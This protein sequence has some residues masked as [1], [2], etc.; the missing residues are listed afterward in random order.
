M[1]ME[2][3]GRSD[4]RGN[5]YEN[6]YLVNLLL[7]LVDEKLSSIIIE[8]VGENSAEFIAETTDGKKIYYQ[9][10]ASNGQADHWRVSDLK[11]HDVWKRAKEIILSDEENYY[12]FVSPV[13]YGD[14][15]E[16]CYRARTNNAPS[17]FFKKQIQDKYH[18]DLVRK[19]ASEFEL[20]IEKEKDKNTLVYILSH[21]FF[22]LAPYTRDTVLNL[23]SQ[24]GVHFAG[25]QKAARIL[26]EQFANSSE[27]YGVKFIPVDVVNY[28]KKKQFEL[29]S[30]RFDDR[31]LPQ[32]EKLNEI[33]WGTFPAINGTLIHR[34][35]TEQVLEKLDLGYSIVLHGRAGSGKSGC[36][37][38]VIEEL[39][40]RGTPYLSIKLD[41]CDP[42]SSANQFG[43]SLDLQESPV[44]ALNGISGGKPCV[45][46]F[47]QLDALRWTA[48]HSSNALSVCK[49]I[50][51]QMRAINRRKEGKISI[52]F[53]SRT[54]D[55][56]NDAGIKELFRE[57]EEHKDDL[58]E[59]VKVDILSPSE[60]ENVVGKRFDNMSSRLK[61][62][63]QT[64]SSLYVWTQLSDE[65]KSRDIS[66][67]FQLMQRWWEQ[68]LAKSEESGVRSEIADKTKNKLVSYIESNNITA[69]PRVLL[70]YYADVL[71]VFLSCGLILKVGNGVAFA[72]QS[73]FD[74]FITQA[75]LDK[76]FSGD[77]I[78][79]C[80]SPYEQQTPQR[81][82]R[83]LYVLQVLLETDSSLFIKQSENLLCSE[84]VHYYYKCAVFE[85]AGQCDDPNDQLFAFI[86]KYYFLPE[87]SET[88]YQSVILRHPG[89]VKK[90]LHEIDL[91]DE[92]QLVLLQSISDKD[93]DFV[94]ECLKGMKID[95]LEDAR[96]VFSVFP[97]DPSKDS[98]SMFRYR[99]EL[100][101][102]FPE[103]FNNFLLF[104]RLIKKQP[105]KAIDFLI[106]LLN[107]ESSGKIDKLYIGEKKDI[108]S[109]SKE[110]YQE[111]IEKLLPVI[112][113]QTSDLVLSWPFSI[114]SDKCKRFEDW[115]QEGR[116]LFSTEHP[117]RTV[118]NIT[119]AAVEEYARQSP[120]EMISLAN[121]KNDSA[122]CHEIIMYGL[123]NLNE[124]L[125]DYVINWI[126]RDFNARI[127]VF[128]GDENDY[129]LYTKQAIS[130]FSPHCT[131]SVFRALENE[132]FRWNEGTSKMVERLRIRQEVNSSKENEPVYYAYWGHLQKELLA[133]MDS[134]RLSQYGE[135]LLAVLNRN[136]W[137]RAPYF[138]CGTR[139]G[140]AKTVVSP[141]D[142]YVD[143]LSDKV[144]MQ[145]IGTPAEKMKRHFGG[146][147][148]EKH[149]I[150]ASHE[151]FSSSMRSQAKKQP[152]RFAELSFAFPDNCY[153]GYICAVLDAISQQSEADN[154]IKDDTLLNRL[155]GRF[156]KDGNRNVLIAV[157]RVV[158]NCKTNW[159][160][161]VIDDIC[162]IALHYAPESKA[163]F[164]VTDSSDP[165]H[166]LARSLLENAINTTRGCAVK[167]LSSQL[168]EK[169]AL[170]EK[171]K[172]VITALCSDKN[173]IVRFA[174]F[175]CLLPFYNIDPSFSIEQM[176]ILLRQDGRVCCA[177]GF[178]ELMIRDY[179]NNPQFYQEQLIKAS[180]SGVED[181]SETAARMLASL[182]IQGQKETELS[183]LEKIDYSEE[184][185]NSIARQAV[186]FYDNEEYHEKS[187]EVLKLLIS[188]TNCELRALL[189]L[190]YHKKIIA[191]RDE[192]FLKYVIS[193]EQNRYILPEMLDY[194]NE[195]DGDLTAF[196]EVFADIAIN[197]DD[198]YA[199]WRQQ[200][201][202]ENLIGC[203]LKLLDQGG[204]D[205]HVREVCLTLWDALYKSNL[206]S[207][208]AL[209]K[210]I[211]ELSIE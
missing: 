144:W 160:P 195:Y 135:Q 118:V 120:E 128:T 201:V 49:E 95:S 121:E 78:V 75:F 80:I 19:I 86:C 69:V 111:V 142:Q 102:R 47:D 58:W 87:W 38:E 165:S 29:R 189:S 14:I 40:R 152:K 81:R 192:E 104:P 2:S 197:L 199:V 110:F 157:S 4:K 41:K 21:C 140:M 179:K 117:V 50:I 146:K 138:C 126:L 105:E 32:V 65:D 150:E 107:A 190:F 31:I 55:L 119:I 169:P 112:K 164:T 141:V 9:C 23:E 116:T 98:N 17:E 178:W 20:D 193:S 8:P 166:L 59:Q 37:Q 172:P 177:P 90:L 16:I 163:D 200:S 18:G 171:M 129:L 130:K 51:G 71:E 74:Y 188:K 5:E 7:R 48:A 122:V 26:L 175:D 186:A 103:M 1:S 62:I 92:K 123:L 97:Y 155:I 207:M 89:F 156:C 176:H 66:S 30:Y 136:E 100:L 57:D 184:Q 60:V 203:T 161:N 11:K 24:V 205:D 124:G 61:R 125:S 28:M 22:E 91:G 202:A 148:N 210:T 174:A 108:A 27:A 115:F 131:D 88:V 70:P 68:I 52:L 206:Q 15:D 12:Y 127:F 191:D 208:Q 13:P 6:R 183:I 209:S 10:K 85:V 134:S 46:I 170:S 180:S 99:L 154:Q 73:I 44:F 143:R 158:E 196:C 3:G 132:I 79:E 211:E 181:L 139:V 185:A 53:A 149:Y 33:Y 168:W 96:R 151:M 133:S 101:S 64:P 39:K 72:H 25:D 93:P 204:A 83:L 145:I 34:E 84:T 198:E 36:L 173:E 56:E 82:Y 43:K 45:L 167:A 182:V 76:V 153:P 114:Y 187:E 35:A 42:D 194:F 106:A 159:N 77:S 109:F 94:M 147:E 137:I 67:V 54:V 63:L 162:E 113:E